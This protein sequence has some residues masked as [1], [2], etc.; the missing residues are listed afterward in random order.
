MFAMSVGWVTTQSSEDR[1]Q[2]PI[3][4]SEPPVSLV[5][6]NTHGA[7][8]PCTAYGRPAPFLEWIR[9]DG[10]VV[11]DV[12]GLLKVHSNNTLQF[13]SFDDD[14]FQTNIH[15]QTYRCLST[16]DAGSVISRSVKVKAGR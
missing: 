6:A 15:I 1:L 3:F 5:F 4:L 11:D 13:Y 16:N 9:E 2:G 14:H 7:T 12:P 8:V 10:S